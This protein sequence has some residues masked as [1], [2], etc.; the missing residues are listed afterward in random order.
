METEKTSRERFKKILE[1]IVIRNYDNLETK[2]EKI[3]NF[4][5]QVQELK[6][7]RLFRYRE[8]KDSTFDALEKNLITSSKPIMFNDPFDSLLYVDKNASFP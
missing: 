5:T 3:K 1:T 4:C 8:F 2:Q 6:P 7:Q